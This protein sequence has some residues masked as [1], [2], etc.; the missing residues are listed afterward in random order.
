MRPRKGRAPRGFGVG[1]LLRRFARV[2]RAVPCAALG[3]ILAGCGAPGD[4]TPRHPVTPQSV[5]DL[6]A[7]QQ[8]DAVVL[9]FT[10]PRISTDQEP[11]TDPPT[12]E[13]Y[14]G[15]IAPGAASPTPPNTRLV[16]TIPGN[17]V[18]TYETDGHFEVRDALDP[19]EIA[20]AP[21]EQLIYMVRARVSAKRASA[22]SNIAAVRVYPVPEAIPDLRATLT[23]QAIVLAWTPPERT[24][25]GAALAAPP[26]YRVYRAELMSDAVA[27]ALASLEDAKLRPRQ[28]IAIPLS[29]LAALTF[30]TSA[31]W[32]HPVRTRSNLRVPI[33]SS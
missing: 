13:I 28:S 19:G 3:G 7:R 31:V 25:A 11:L 16:D 1:C 6:A 29:S 27:A 9:T 21:G 2:L 33:P 17:L 12:V 26:A 23:E 32:C 5:T 4:P 24:G 8:G 20:R 30:M 10:L 15:S 18:D 22:D 14:R